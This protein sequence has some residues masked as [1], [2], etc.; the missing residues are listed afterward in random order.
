MRVNKNQFR[1]KNYPETSFALIDESLEQVREALNHLGPVQNQRNEQEPGVKPQFLEPNPEIFT[2][3]FGSFEVAPIENRLVEHVSLDE[4]PGLAG[5]HVLAEVEL[6]DP[7][8]DLADFPAVETGVDELRPVFLLVPPE[9]RV[10]LEDLVE[11]LLA[12]HVTVRRNVSNPRELSVRAFHQRPE[13][14]QNDVVLLSHYKEKKTF[15]L[16]FFFLL[17]IRTGIVSFRGHRENEKKREKESERDGL[18]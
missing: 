14:S 15:F 1:E 8:G 13:R 17:V 7:A 10:R 5:P 6:A 11:V 9:L 3:A 12:R 16:F 2:E 4:K 18:L